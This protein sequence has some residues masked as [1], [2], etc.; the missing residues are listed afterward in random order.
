MAPARARSNTNRPIPIKLKRPAA[1]SNGVMKKPAATTNNSQ[2]RR[3]KQQDV[4]Q[5]GRQRTMKRPTSSQQRSTQLAQIDSMDWLRQALKKATFVP[6]LVLDM[7]SCRLEY[8]FTESDVPRHSYQENIVSMISDVMLGIR[9]S[10]ESCLE[11]LNEKSAALELAKLT[12]SATVHSA[13]ATLDNTRKNVL[14][15]KQKCDEMKEAKQMLSTKLHEADLE[16]VAA[17]SRLKDATDEKHKLNQALSFLKHNILEH[18]D[19]QSMVK[20]LV[21]LAQKMQLDEAMIYCMQQG[22]LQDPELRQDVQTEAID[23]FETILQQNSETFSNKL[24]DATTAWQTCQDKFKSCQ[25]DFDEMT[26]EENTLLSTQAT[27]KQKLLQAELAVQSAL[28]SQQDLST[29]LNAFETERSLQ[30]TLLDEFVNGALAR[31]RSL[32]NKSCPD[33]V[34]SQNTSATPS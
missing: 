4:P 30:M 34:E 21:E 17:Q 13:L 24:Q 15:A 18:T 25:Q 5:S 6:P 10:L 1:S 32:L 11:Q 19:V 31:Y 20:D 14:T 29:E 12:R 7:L 9:R 16:L 27:A 22:L 26:C 23:K 3:R 8:C 33:A 2:S 28:H